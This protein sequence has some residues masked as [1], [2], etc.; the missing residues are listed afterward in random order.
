MTYTM[1]AYEAKARFS[2]VIRRIRSGQRV[3]ITYRGEEV[4]EVRPVSRETG[5]L[6]KRLAELE[7]RGSLRRSGKRWE[8][9][10]VATKPGALDRFLRERE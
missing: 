4:A 3:I 8:P 7:S 5:G 2:E 10:T 9:R 6:A 1:S